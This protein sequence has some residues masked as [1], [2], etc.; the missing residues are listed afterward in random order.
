MV[1]SRGS[2]GGAMAAQCV[3]GNNWISFNSVGKMIFSVETKTFH[4]I[5]RKLSAIHRRSE[6]MLKVVNF[7]LFLKS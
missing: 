2:E 1:N 5:F 4:A 3:C 6:T 7:G